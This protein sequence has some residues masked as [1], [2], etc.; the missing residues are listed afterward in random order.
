MEKMV[1]RDH[2]SHRPTSSRQDPS[3]TCPLNFN[4]FYILP[5]LANGSNTRERPL[6]MDDLNA[7]QSRRSGNILTLG[8]EFR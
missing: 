4:D 6:P 7:M 3:R 1:G 2:Q 8:S 5:Q